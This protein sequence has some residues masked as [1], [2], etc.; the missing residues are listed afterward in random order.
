MGSVTLILC[1][2]SPSEPPSSARGD[3]LQHS[4]V[5]DVPL[6]HIVMKAMW[7]ILFVTLASQREI[8]EHL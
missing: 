8:R 6:L 1:L 2:E 3:G 5:L 4:S 7:K